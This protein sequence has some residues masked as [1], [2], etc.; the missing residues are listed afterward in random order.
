MNGLVAWL[1]GCEKKMNIEP[2]LCV[3]CSVLCFMKKCTSVRVNAGKKDFEQ[4]NRGVGWL[5]AVCCFL[6]R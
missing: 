6:K 4:A 2:V 5:F 3:L 1:V